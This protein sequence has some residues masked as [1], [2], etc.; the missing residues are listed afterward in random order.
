MCT[1]EACHFCLDIHKSE[2][3]L[4]WMISQSVWSPVAIQMAQVPEVQVQIQVKT[5]IT[6]KFQ[7][8]PEMRQLYCEMERP[9]NLPSYPPKQHYGLC[10][11]KGIH[12][13]SDVARLNK[14]RV[15]CRA[16]RAGSKNRLLDQP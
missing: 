9:G 1:S 11:H 5:R 8:L 2:A 10:R 12:P 3:G 16:T 6:G 13:G 15:P 7:E 4:F 14:V